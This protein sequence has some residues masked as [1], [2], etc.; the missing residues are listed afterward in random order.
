MTARCFNASVPC[1][2]LSLTH[3]TTGGFKVHKMITF[4]IE[5]SLTHHAAP[6]R[7]FFFVE[8]SV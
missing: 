2:I 3:L 1:G 8:I 4:D 6:R 5:D 7:A